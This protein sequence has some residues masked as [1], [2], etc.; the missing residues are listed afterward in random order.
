[1]FQ[2]TVNVKFQVA[3]GQENL[4]DNTG[5]LAE[6]YITDLP[7]EGTNPIFTNSLV[8]IGKKRRW[9]GGEK[10]AGMR[11]R[12]TCWKN[13]LGSRISLIFARGCRF[14]VVLT[15]GCDLLSII[16][17]DPRKRGKNKQECLAAFKLSQL[18]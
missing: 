8:D 5:C 7:K 13:Q 3:Q 2:V 17:A 10:L 1:V 12:Q 9:W 16:P 6:Q 15:I 4:A 11:Q 14:F 18:F